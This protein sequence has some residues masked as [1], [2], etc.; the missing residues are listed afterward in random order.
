MLRSIKVGVLATALISP[1]LAEVSDGQIEQLISI[2]GLNEQVT[3]FPSLVQM[4]LE[5]IKSQMDAETYQ[6]LVEQA[7]EHLDTEEILA[8][9]GNELSRELDSA[10]ASEIIAWYQSPLGDQVVQ[11][12]SDAATAADYQ[13]MLQ[14]AETLQQNERL[15][16]YASDISQGNQAAEMAYN[17]QKHGALASFRGL[18]YTL[19]PE[20]ADQ[21][22]AY[23]AELESA[24][25]QMRAQLQQLSELSFAYAFRDL[26]DEQLDGYVEFLER[27]ATQAFTGAVEDGLQTGMQQVTEDWIEAIRAE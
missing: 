24:A 20:K 5:Q 7:N 6:A 18:I 4:G 2:S 26:T 22:S 19:A 9:V 27:P 1:A 21:I 17:L 23:E 16:A 11:A 25:P 8:A 10:Q 14:M 13:N 3:Q 15:M 12:E